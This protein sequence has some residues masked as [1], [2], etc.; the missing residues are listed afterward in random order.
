M[1]VLV[2]KQKRTPICLIL[3]VL[4]LKMFASGFESVCDLVH[5]YRETVSYPIY[6]QVFNEYCLIC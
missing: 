2:V 6:K 5:K 1:S 3:C 4:H